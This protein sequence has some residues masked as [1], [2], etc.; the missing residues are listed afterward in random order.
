MII[1]DTVTKIGDRA[2]Y[3]CSA[4]MPV[5]IP[6]SVTEIGE[7][8]F[9]CSGTILDRFLGSLRTSSTIPDGAVTLASTWISLYHD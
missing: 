2:F 6:E 7:Y 5:T 9:D 3:D 1:P 4:L 8:V